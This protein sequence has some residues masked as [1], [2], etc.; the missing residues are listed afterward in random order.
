MKM[1]KKLRRILLTVCSAALLVCV[2]VGATTAYLTSKATVTNTFTI[3]KLAIT[4]DE[5]DVTVYG[6]KDTDERVVENSYKIM[7]GHTYIKDPQ[8]HFAW[9]GTEAVD[10]EDAYL[11]VA[12]KNELAAIEETETAE[13]GYKNINSQIL[14]NG[15][16]TLTRDGVNDGYTVYYKRVAGSAT[17][18]DY[19]VF[20]SFKT[21]GSLSGT[22]IAAYEGKTIV[23]K[24]Y[25]IQ[26]DGFGTADA[27]DAAAAWT[28]SGF[29]PASN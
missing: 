10:S 28:A 19:N 6:E 13:N 3:G 20:A 27:P 23:V 9:N 7:P 16:T 1:N 2:T 24:A 17:K 25:A 14:G 12:V 29:N 8:I 15:W 22:D 26:A 5:T 11:F 4:K 21:Q 18:V